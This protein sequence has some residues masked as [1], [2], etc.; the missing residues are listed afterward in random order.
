MSRTVPPTILRVGLTGGIASG[1]STVA[2]LLAG[3]GAAIID[4]DVVAREVVAPGTPA[5]AEIAEEFGAGMLRPDGTLDRAAMRRVVFA[6][7]ER[8]CRLEA[9]LHPRIRARSLELA[10][11]RPGPY[12]VFVV[13]LLVETDF[14][15]LVDRVLVVDCAP[16]TQMNRLVQRDG[17]SPEEALRMIGSQ[18]TR[19]ERLA[20]AD[21]V[22]R[23]D[24]DLAALEEAVRQLH[25]QYLALMIS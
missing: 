11:E 25:S 14:A 6:D 2:R 17:I 16:E 1:K 3:H 12:Q 7:P 9:I 4:T 15:A 19:D 21:D 24:G 13:P 5:L 22:V 8:R 20:V 18:A 23:N 10:A